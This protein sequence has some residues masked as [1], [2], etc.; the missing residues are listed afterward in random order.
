MDNNDNNIEVDGINPA[1][2]SIILRLAKNRANRAKW[3]VNILVFLFTILIAIIILI[4]LNIDTFIIALVA[5]VGLGLVLLLG[6]RRSN[7]LVHH[8]YAEELGALRQGSNNEPEYKYKD[9]KITTREKEVL[10]HAAQG[11]TN[12]M[13]AAQLGISTNTVKV[14]MS[15]IMEKLEANDRT[16]AVVIAI[17]Q[18]IISIK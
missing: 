8:Y 3:D 2:K 12:K 6:N 9:N 5:V 1:V 17:K 15:L 7:S 14:F 4:S 11:F 18:S 16:E 13:I 10:S